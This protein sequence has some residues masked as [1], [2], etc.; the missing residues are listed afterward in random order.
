MASEKEIIGWYAEMLWIEGLF[1]KILNDYD[2]DDAEDM[3]ADVKYCAKRLSKLKLIILKEGLADVNQR[4]IIS[5]FSARAPA[6][7]RFTHEP[8]R[9]WTAGFGIGDPELEG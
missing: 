8:E 1:G 3:E 4:Q 9:P 7:I 2:F 5:T 6:D